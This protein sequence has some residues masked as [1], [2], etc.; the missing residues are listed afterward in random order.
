MRCGAYGQTAESRRKR[1]SENRI[2][3]SEKLL[4]EMEAS[5]NAFN[6]K[7][8]AALC[9]V[10]LLCALCNLVGIF[11]VDEQVMRIAVGSSFVAFFLPILVWLIH[12][13]FR[14]KRPPFCN[15]AA[16]NS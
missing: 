8:L 14:K 10:T 5:A 4:L 11:I 16:S 13:K 15:G 2:Q 3:G 1:I 6:L 7:C 12:D 9:G